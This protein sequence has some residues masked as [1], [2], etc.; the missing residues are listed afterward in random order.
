MGDLCTLP[1]SV[2]SLPCTVKIR[3]DFL[4]PFARMVYFL[5]RKSQSQCQQ[6]LGNILVHTGQTTGRPSYGWKMSRMAAAPC[7]AM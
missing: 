1:N 5:S 7:G 3:D 4:Y 2:F 6:E